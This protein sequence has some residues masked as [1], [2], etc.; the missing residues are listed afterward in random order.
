MQNLEIFATANSTVA[1][2]RDSANAKTVAAP[3]FV[4]GISATLTLT[5]FNSPD[6]LLPLP[7]SALAGISAWSFVFDDD[8]NS[9]TDYKIVADN[10]NITWTGGLT[11]G[12]TDEDGNYIPTVFTIPLPNMNSVALNEWLGTAASK[13]GL[14]GELVGYDSTGAYV[15]VLQIQGFTVRNRVTASGEPEQPEEATE[16]LT[17]DQARAMFLSENNAMKPSLDVISYKPDGD[18]DVDGHYVYY[19]KTTIRPGSIP[20]NGLLE[21]VYFREDRKAFVRYNDDLQAWVVYKLPTI[22]NPIAKYIFKWIK[23]GTNPGPITA[24]YD[25]ASNPQSGYSAGVTVTK[26]YNITAQTY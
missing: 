14:I 13:S 23:T 8:F 10:E 6:D 24:V 5:L 19:E 7:P 18:P 21:D 22:G 25:N 15:F 20:A 26:R 11:D 1:T 9:E 3:M 4:I 16:F 2:V 17:V 12:E